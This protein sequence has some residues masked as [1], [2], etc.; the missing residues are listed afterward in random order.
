MIS[1]GDEGDQGVERWLV[2]Y[3]DV[4]AQ[5]LP[6]ERPVPFLVPNG[7]PIA[8]TASVLNPSQG[9]VNVP[10]IFGYEYALGTLLLGRTSVLTHRLGVR[11]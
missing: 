8:V 7:N 2:N 6:V 9:V 10:M 3:D 5:F 1:I 4:A 11:S